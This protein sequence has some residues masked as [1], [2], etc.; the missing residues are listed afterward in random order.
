M[1]PC[2][3]Q[4]TFGR[5]GARAGPKPIKSKAGSTD[6]K[7]TRGRSRRRTGPLWATERE[8]ARNRTM[9]F[10]VVRLRSMLDKSFDL[11]LRPGFARNRTTLARG[12]FPWARTRRCRPPPG[13]SRANCARSRPK[14]RVESKLGRSGWR[15]GTRPGTPIGQ[16]GI[17]AS[18]K[19][20]PAIGGRL[21]STSE[22]EGALG[23]AGTRGSFLGLRP[24]WAT[25]S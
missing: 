11:S 5:C 15:A 8:L 22:R 9:L 6:T 13:R 10:R 4:A 19:S 16:H 17:H 20:G 25:T 3:H 21:E 12:R 14:A 24:S 2:R 7:Q 23:C 1:T 18:P